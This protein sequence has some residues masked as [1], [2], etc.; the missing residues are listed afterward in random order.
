MHELSHLIRDREP[1]QIILSA[2][3]EFAMRSFDP[4]QE[5][6]ANWLNG[7][8]LL[9]RDALMQC[10]QVGNTSEQIAQQYGVSTSL[11][12]YRLRVTGI[13]QQFS[14]RKRFRTG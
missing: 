6:E 8:L 1:S 10:R 9:P 4:K 13:E 5:D 14:R 3:G 11:T 7:T 12:N 2:T